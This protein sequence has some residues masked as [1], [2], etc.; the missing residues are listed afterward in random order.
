[1]KITNIRTTPLLCKFK[2]DYH[3]ADG[4]TLCSPVVLI[5][6]ETDE[7]IVGIAESG[8]GPTIEPM[9]AILHDAIPSFIGKSVFD[10]NK[11]IWDYFRS[12]FKARGA[13]GQ[14]RFF[15]RT[16]SGIELALWD[17][18]GKS[19]GQP[20]CNIL[21]GALHDKVGYFGFVQGDTPQELAEH[22][23]RLANEGYPVLY[24]KVGRDDKLDMEIVKA[25]RKAAPDV[26]LRL[27]ANEAWDTLRALRMMERLKAFDIE[28]MEQ[29]VPGIG[30]S[31]ALLRLR[32]VGMPVSADQSVYMPEDVYEMC[33]TRAADTIV[34]GL[35][36]TCGA[37][38]WRKAAAIAEA[39]NI[40]INIHGIFET[41]VTT[42]IANQV[43]ATVPNLDDANQIMWQLLEEDIVENP[44]LTPVNGFLT[45]MKKPGYGFDLNW[46]AVGRAAEVYRKQARWISH[47]R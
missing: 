45:V 11:L 33:R 29:P 35:H 4:I 12:G 18:I 5:E 34:L 37:L 40:R 13:G 25:V 36:E 22:A 47:P 32:G 8:V 38:R 39:A 3:W 17:A 46:D 41:G 44:N 9:L 26:R 16:M 2:Q 6:V 42:C 23:S 20:V 1:M 15:S 27:D 14:Y 10:G 30:G 28:I 7:G 21:G 19:Y 31:E 43:G 24:V